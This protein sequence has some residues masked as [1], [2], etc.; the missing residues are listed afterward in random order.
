[1]NQYTSFRVRQVSIKTHQVSA[2]PLLKKLKVGLMV[3]V[4]GVVMVISPSV[5][6]EKALVPGMVELRFGVKKLPDGI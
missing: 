4:L 3:Q 6:A 1:M 5:R 2:C